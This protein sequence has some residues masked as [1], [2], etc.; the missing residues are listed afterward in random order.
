M[1][2]KPDDPRQMFFVSREELVFRETLVRTIDE[3]V[4]QLDLDE[5]YAGWSE[6][7]RPFY[8]PAMML[9][10][11]FFSYCEGERSSRKIARKIIY[12][13]R[14]QYFTGT[15]RPD[16]RTIC[17]FRIKAPDLLAKFFVQIVRL[18]DE[19][20]LL[21]VTQVAIDGTKIKA[22]ASGKRTYRKKDRDRL[23]EK[24]KKLLGEDAGKERAEV[25]G[26]DIDE[27]EEAIAV[28]VEALSENDLRDRVRQAKERLEAG[29]SEVNLTDLDSKFMKDS[30]GVIEPCF[31]GQVV[32][33][34]N[35]FIMAADLFV[36]VDDTALLQPMVEQGKANV[37]S[38]LGIILVDGGYFSGGNLKYIVKEGLEVYM[39]TGKGNPEPETKFSR[40]DFVYDEKTDSYICPAGERLTYK[41][42]R[43]KKDLES[44]VYRC[45]SSKCRLCKLKSCCTTGRHRELK[46]SEVWEHERAMKEKLSTPAGR[47]IS[48]RRKVLV[49]PVFGNMKFNMG[50]A[51]FVLRGLAKA[52]GEFMLMCIAH[53]LKKMSKYWGQLTTNTGVDVVLLNQICLNIVFLFAIRSKFKAW[54]RNPSQKIKYAC[55]FCV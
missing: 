29:E 24:Y 45:S 7:G 22:S 36:N 49:E 19:A 37:T 41:T 38:R 16:F 48:S 40:Y 21:D 4:N 3:V 14:Y 23:T 53:N 18:C 42:S 44:K 20:G 55:Q 17:R 33:E 35:Q 51:R 11:L 30:K 27:E 34:K 9:K 39:P 1:I 12:D 52:K 47:E 8:D 25:N 32:T 26:D 43:R 6:K 50:F 10:L 28:E 46:I 2:L 13:I 15:L 31:N 5:L 54:W